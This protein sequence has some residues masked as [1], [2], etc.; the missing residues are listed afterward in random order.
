MVADQTLQTILSGLE[1]ISAAATFR[2][3]R[4]RAIHL[5]PPDSRYNTKIVSEN[6]VCLA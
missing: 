6:P 2:A 1:V 3:L 5:K 4:F